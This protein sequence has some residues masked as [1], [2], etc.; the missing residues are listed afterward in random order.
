MTHSFKKKIDMKIIITENKYVQGI[1]DFLETNYY[2]D[3]NWVSHSDYQH[4][5]EEYGSVEFYINDSGSY[6]YIR[7]DDG[8]VLII[9]GVVSEPLNNLF[10]YKWV[11]IFKKWFEENTGLEVNEI[12]ITDN[13]GDQF[14][15]QFKFDNT[16]ENN[17][18]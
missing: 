15:K 17:N 18:N 14:I 9:Y 5:V 4:E 7:K 11:P 8:G 13:I 2:P 10:G 1:L 3:Y 12:T 6:V 16:N